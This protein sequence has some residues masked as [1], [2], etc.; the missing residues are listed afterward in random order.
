MGAKL[1]V[2]ASTVITRMQI[3]DN[4]EGVQDVVKS[5]LSGA[6]LYVESRLGTSLEIQ[7]HESVYLLDKD[8]FSA[9]QPGGVFRIEVPAYFIRG[10]DTARPIVVSVADN[11]KMI[12]AEVVD[13]SRGLYKVHAEDGQLSLD[14]EFF[15][16]KYVKVSCWTG[17]DDDAVLVEADPLN[18][19]EEERGPEPLPAWLEEAILS[20]VGAVF[21]VSQ[22]T[23]RS[24]K[25][26]SQY[27]NAAKHANAVVTP[28]L[29]K[30]GFVFRPVA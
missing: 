16:D 13:T 1:F 12:G 23:N 11:W 25:A 17:F 22:T 8:A 18:G 6:H 2:T 10:N 4:L 5:A 15:A 30:K 9:I 29:R 14:A 20:Y 3:S 19:V 28:H 26:K 27:D 7:Q 24:D 21:D